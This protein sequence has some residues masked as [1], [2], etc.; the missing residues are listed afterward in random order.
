M[1]FP[2]SAAFTLTTSDERLIQLLKDNTKLGAADS[3]RKVIKTV[4][5]FSRGI[6]V[7]DVTV[8]AMTCDTQ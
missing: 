3:Q 1:V 6:L 7:D 5:E 4:Y 2:R 8:V